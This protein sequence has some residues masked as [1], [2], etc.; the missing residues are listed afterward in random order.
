MHKLVEG[1][2]EVRGVAC[3]SHVLLLGRCSV[4]HLCAALPLSIRHTLKTEKQPAHVLAPKEDM[5]LCSQ[6]STMFLSSSCAYAGSCV[7]K[8]HILGQ[9]GELLGQVLGQVEGAVDIPLH[10]HRLSLISP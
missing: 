9:A 8:A 4:G 2:Q 5:C 1:L 7:I 3:L 10:V 6:V